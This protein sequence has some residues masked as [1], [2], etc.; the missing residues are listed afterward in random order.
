MDFLHRT[1]AEISISALVHNFK[2]IKESSNNCSLMAVVK[3][4]AYG[5]DTEI[6]I[7]ALLSTGVD[8]F[9]VSNIDEAE[10]LRRLGVKYP[11]LILGYTPPEAAFRLA[12]NNIIQT[13]YDKDFAE[14]LSF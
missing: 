3:A 13:V 5:H 10:E 4:D 14:K 6:V 9:A 7:P 2:T 8:S 1:W 12:E 11:I